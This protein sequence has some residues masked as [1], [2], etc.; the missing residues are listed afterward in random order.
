MK[1]GIEFIKCPDCKHNQAQDPKHPQTFS[2]ANCGKHFN[3]T[4]NIMGKY[5]VITKGRR[6]LPAGMRKQT[7]SGVRVYPYDVERIKK[8]GYTQQ[9][10]YDA[11]LKLVLDM[12]KKV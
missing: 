1:R 9:Q 5:E 7:V 6:P 3:Y 2:C 11:G 4:V 12:G 8:L 10:V